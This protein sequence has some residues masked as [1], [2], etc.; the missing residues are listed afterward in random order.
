MKNFFWKTKDGESILIKN[1]STDHLLNTTSYLC[2]RFVG[3]EEDLP[4]EYWV[5]ELEIFL[6]RH[7]ELR[8]PFEFLIK[9]GEAER[10]QAK[11]RAELKDIE[12]CQFDIDN[13][14]GQ[15]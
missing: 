7:E 13:F 12:M 2:R 8:K 3:K 1:M 9:I 6:R 15:S 11:R 14:G 5:M 10:R 4:P